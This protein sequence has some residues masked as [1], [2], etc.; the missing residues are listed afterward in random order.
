M[1]KKIREITIDKLL[2]LRSDSDKCKSGEKKNHVET[3]VTVGIRVK[4][5]DAIFTVEL[6]LI[7]QKI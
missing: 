4:E 6:L 5:T 7:R 2:R 1:S 3:G